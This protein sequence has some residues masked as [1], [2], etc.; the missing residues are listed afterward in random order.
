MSQEK[1]LLVILGP[2]T[3]GKS[4]LAVKCALEFNG[5]VISADS[6][7][8]Y[9]G[10]DV[11]T[12]KISK[13][14]MKDVPHHL[15]D[16]ADPKDQYSVALY[17]EE[18]ERA[19]ED[20]HA[21][22]M[23]PILTGGTGF[24][25]QAVVDGVILPDVPPNPTLRKELE[26]K[27]TDELRDIL[28]QLDPRRESDIKQDNPRRLIRAIEIA[29]ELGHVPKIK[30]VSRFDTL[31]IGLKP[32]KES[33]EKNIKHRTQ[34][35]INEGMIEEAKRLHNSGITFVRMR[36]LGLE[37]KHLADHLEG[38]I[39]KKELINRIEKDDLKYAVRQMRWFKRD[40]RIIWFK[41]ENEGEIM[42]YVSK[43][44]TYE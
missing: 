26:E 4:E 20:I 8:V 17:K 25:I 21:R 42:K 18:A 30:R 31:Q 24:F 10:L 22:N 13:E 2:T 38:R 1:K 15:L 39:D 11:A 32:T 5:E 44:L 3:S 36:E 12:G 33:L 41:P 29:T 9:K 19:I 37:Y 7:Q 34:R 40:D 23:L 16:V 35:R 14:E 43:W 6:R 27:T 28:E